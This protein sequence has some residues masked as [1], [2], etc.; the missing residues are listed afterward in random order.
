MTIWLFKELGVPIS[1]S[2]GAKLSF[3]EMGHFDQASS[4]FVYECDE[5]DRNFLAFHPYTAMITGITWDHHE[6]FPTIEEYQ[7]AFKS[8]MNQSEKVVMWD[9][10]AELL[11]LEPNDSFLLLKSADANVSNISLTGLVNRQNAWQVI[12][13]V[14]SITKEPLE[15]LIE[16]MND[17]P[18]LARRMEQIKPNLYSDYAHTPE[19]IQG[20][21]GIALEMAQ[22]KNQ[23][24]AVVYEPLTN[25]RMHYMATQHTDI[26]NGASTI[27]WVPSYLAREDPN[28]EVLTPSILIKNLNPA[29]QEIAKPME[30]NDQLKAVI[31]SHLNAG[32]LVIA[33]TGG[34]GHSLDEWLRDQFA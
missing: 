22:E 20:A 26:F 29:L 33:M 4:Y 7:T 1:Y 19:K 11:H 10:D 2:V 23:K 24:V 3:G 8:F 9:Q 16:I 15:H 17:F 27:Y 5:F 21:M 32:D 34:G 6:V 13:T 12:S 25:R 18:G 30:L 14:Q 28:Q 31:E